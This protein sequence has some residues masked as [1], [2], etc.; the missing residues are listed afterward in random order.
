MEMTNLEGT[1]RFLMAAATV[2]LD[3]EDECGIRRLLETHSVQVIPAQGVQEAIATAA[4]VILLDG[5]GHNSWAKSLQEIL[6]ARPA[7]RVVVLAR[8]ADN[9]MWADVLSQG[10]HDLLQKPLVPSEVRFVVLG[11]LRTE[12]QIFASA[13]AV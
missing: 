5:D 11:A 4:P 10:A 7:A 3:A 8:N 1:S 2:F 9:R 6:T 13:M 12:Q